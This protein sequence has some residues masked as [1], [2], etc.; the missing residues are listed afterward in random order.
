MVLGLL[1]SLRS[2]K[3]QLFGM[4]KYLIFFIF[5][6]LLLSNDHVGSI[7]IYE[8]EGLDR[9]N[10]YVELEIPSCLI[11]S[12]NN[13]I[14]INKTNHDTIVCQVSKKVNIFNGILCNTIIFPVDISAYDSLSY[15]IIVSDY[16]DSIKNP[17]TLN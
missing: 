14:A 15:N 8:L 12:G 17:I 10:E 3:G 16:I 7:Q 11:I 5:C 9:S 1:I 6:G 2:Q 4:N 13:L